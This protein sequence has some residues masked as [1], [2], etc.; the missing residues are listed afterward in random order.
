[1]QYLPTNQPSNGIQY[2]QL[3]PTRPLIVPISPYLPHLPQYG[4][5]QGTAL[6]QVTGIPSYSSLGGGQNYAAAQ[7]YVSAGQNYGP[8]LSAIGHHYPSYQSNSPG[9]YAAASSSPVIS[10]FRPHTGIQMINGPIDM[11]L[12]TNEYIPIQAESAYKMRRA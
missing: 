2:L 9:G 6:Q 5:T 10:F 1:M 4:S 3:L 8:P 7:N 11:S 12:N